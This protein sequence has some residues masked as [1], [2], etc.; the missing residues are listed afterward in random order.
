MG[1]SQS[2]STE[3]KTN[4]GNLESVIQDY[5]PDRFGQATGLVHL[6]CK[7]GS[8][9]YVSYTSVPKSIKIKTVDINGRVQISEINNKDKKSLLDIGLL[10]SWKRIK[11]YQENGLKIT[12]N[13]EDIY[14]TGIKLAN[15]TPMSK[16]EFNSNRY[17]KTTISNLSK[18]KKFKD[19][20][21]HYAT[22]I[23]EGEEKNHEYGGMSVFKSKS[24][25]SKS[26]CTGI[27]YCYDEFTD[28]FVE[29]VIT[30]HSKNNGA[31]SS[32]CPDASTCMKDNGFNYAAAIDQEYKLRSIK[33]KKSSNSVKR[34]IER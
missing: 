12:A 23:L 20:D 25:C 14:W 33:D 24:G 18:G 5:D 8:N 17:I 10:P 1:Y 7:N 34:A 9:G 6:E 16:E 32:T 26:Y 15:T 11:Y 22:R 2:A 21:C 31:S 30:C 19:G 27:A 29:S 13:T 28:T 3:C 4:A